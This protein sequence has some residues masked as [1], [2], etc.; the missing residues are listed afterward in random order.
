MIKPDADSARHV[1]GSMR[2]LSMLATMA[3]LCMPATTLHAA[4]PVK[5]LSVEHMLSEKSFGDL[6]VSPDERWYAFSVCDPAE[7]SPRLWT[8]AT[9]C[10]VWVQQRGAAQ[11][12]RISTGMGIELSWSPDGRYLAYQAYE[13]VELKLWLW[14]RDQGKARK[15][16]DLRLAWFTQIPQP[17]QWM[18][19]GRQVLVKYADGGGRSL[20]EADDEDAK[21]PLWARKPSAGKA[22]VRSTAMMRP[23]ADDKAKPGMDVVSQV[24]LALVEVASGRHRALYPAQDIRGARLSPD[25]RRVAYTVR[26]GEVDEKYGS[27]AWQLGVL[28]IATGKQR[29]LA[30]DIFQ[31]HGMNFSWSPDSRRLAYVSGPQDHRFTRE[32]GA[33]GTQLHVVTVDDGAH[34]SYHG[35][36]QLSVHGYWAPYWTCD[37][38]RV[39]IQAQDGLWRGDVATGR[40][41]RVAMPENHPVRDLVVGAG[42]G[43]RESQ[44]R[45]DRKHDKT[46][47]LLARDVMGAQDVWVR[48]KPDG[49]VEATAL[50]RSVG[51]KSSFF[52]EALLIDGGRKLLGFAEAA[53]KPAELVEFDAD[54]RGVDLT[55]FNHLL[56]PYAYGSLRMIEFDGPGGKLRAAVLLPAGFREG[57]RYPAVIELYPGL[58][59]SGSASRQFGLGGAPVSNAQMLATRGYVTMILDSETRAGTLSRD[60]VGAANAGADELIQRGWA[61]PARMGM[62]GCSHAGYA[63]LATL[64]HTDRFKAGLAECGFAD[65]G[66]FWGYNWKHF[67]QYGIG[68]MMVPPWEDPAR[69]VEHSPY[70][71]AHRMTTPLM[72]VVGGDDSPEFV[73]QSERMFVALN[74]LGR[75]AVLVKYEGEGHALLRADTLR[76]FWQ[77]VLAFFD[78]K[79]K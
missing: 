62:R 20:S 77:R 40:L 16:S 74:E 47:H 36:P 70:Y 11:P 24:G 2:V 33:P 25:G 57:Q 17:V 52:H 59:W 61:D 1:P 44:Y 63:V 76:D 49:A 45:C 35:E 26:T 8:H 37:S 15:V 39:F 58:P 30:R 69:Y 3:A 73:Q 64:M 19:D 50:G 43:Y 79:L 14:D 60:V 34:R 27:S 72:L 67:I 28:D 23:V 4:N 56:A 10:S 65:L 38:R 21:L 55:R 6:A 51:S 9:G 29:I 54:G 31:M 66:N 75:E 5:P 22:S 18:P 13:G 46:V 68:K 42:A 53:D 78:A 12:T 7:E 41:G 48:V 32:R 71:H